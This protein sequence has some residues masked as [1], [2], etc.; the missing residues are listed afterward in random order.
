MLVIPRN[1]YLMMSVQRPNYTDIIYIQIPE[2]NYSNIFRIDHRPKTIQSI[3]SI[4]YI[5]YIIPIFYGSHILYNTLFYIISIALLLETFY[6]DFSCR[7]GD[8]FDEENRSPTSQIHISCLSSTQ[9]ISNMRNRHRLNSFADFWRI[10][11]KRLFFADI[12]VYLQGLP[13]KFQGVPFGSLTGSEPEITTPD[14]ISDCLGAWGI[15]PS[16]RFHN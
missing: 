6:C 16:F 10:S 7:V 3:V 2:Q 8:L 13:L 15:N 9:T 12:F 14:H 5:F 11:A 4:I 1:G